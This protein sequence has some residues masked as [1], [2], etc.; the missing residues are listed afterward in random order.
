M[1]LMIDSLQY[2]VFDQISLNNEV[3]LGFTAADKPFQA[4]KIHI[5]NREFHKSTEFFWFRVNP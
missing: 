1:I 5:C 3:V 2:L 4:N